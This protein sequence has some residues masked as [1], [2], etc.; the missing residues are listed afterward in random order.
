[1]SEPITKVKLNRATPE[2]N[3]ALVDTWIAQTSDRINYNMN[4][5]D[6]SNFSGNSEI[7]TRQ[8]VQ[9]MIDAAVS[10]MRRLVI[11]ATTE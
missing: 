3:I 4:N 7:M 2:E 6:L 11:A 10:E 5:L 8:S 9:E 1:M